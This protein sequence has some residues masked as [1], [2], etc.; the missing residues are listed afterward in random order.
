MMSLEKELLEGLLVNRSWLQEHGFNRSTVDFYLRSG[1]LIPIARGVYRK[2]GPPIKWQNIAYSLIQLGFRLHV[3]QT[4]ALQ[5]HGY[6]HYLELSGKQ[7]IHLYSDRKLPSWI[8]EVDGDFHFKQM[9]GR[10]FPVSV[11][12][13][14]VEVPFGTWDW[15]IPYSSPERAFIEIA[16]TAD[17]SEDISKL[18][19]M[20]EG[21]VNL[22]PDVL[23]VLLASCNQVKGKRLFL[24]LG[25]EAGHQWYKKLHIKA[26]NL[27][28]GKRQIVKGGVLD[29]DFLI[30]V[31]GNGGYGQKESIF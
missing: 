13:G 2:P 9:S 6:Q 5:F 20:F 10:L 11:Q 14:L 16:C 12:S 30:T 29:K 18:Q 31:P 26:V 19:T 8:Y 17:T 28:S 27:G 15:M 21:A 24:W 3:G 25:R 7:L 23:Q 4:T 22:R 1:R